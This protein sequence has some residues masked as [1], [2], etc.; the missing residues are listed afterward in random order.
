MKIK[1]PTLV[2]WCRAESRPAV[3]SAALAAVVL[4][5]LVT[6][7][8]A[9]TPTPTPP[10]S[11]GGSVEVPVVNLDVLVTDSDG[12]PVLD[13]KASD[14][15]LTVDGEPVPLSHFAPPTSLSGETEPTAEAARQ[16]GPTP[17]PA[18]EGR[19]Y[20]IVFVD[21]T[22]YDRQRLRAG[23]EQVS[24]FLGGTGKLPVPVMV[25]SFDGRLRICQSF[26]QNRDA[27]LASLD[28]CK[29]SSATRLDL[30]HEK[31]LMK[32]R[33]SHVAA[34]EVPPSDPTRETWERQV[35]ELYYQ[36]EQSFDEVA[37]DQTEAVLDG[38]RHCVGMLAG[39]PGRK[40]IVLM[41]DGVDAHATRTM[42]EVWRGT[43]TR[44]QVRRERE[45]VRA[46]QRALPK[47]QGY[48]HATPELRQ[49]VEV[50]NANRITFFTLTSLSD[51]L[52][53]QLSAEGS[54]AG[55][56]EGA[57]AELTEEIVLYRMADLTGGRVLSTGPDLAKQL[58]KVSEEMGQLYLLAFVPPVAN[59]GKFHRIQVAV[60]RE[61]VTVSHRRGWRASTDDDQLVAKTLA[62]A[63]METVDNPLDIRVEEIGREPGKSGEVK[64][65]IMV[66]MPIAKLVLLPGEKS[67]E[68]ATSLCLVIRDDAERLSNVYRE[69]FPVTV[70]DDQLERALSSAA[71]FRKVL[72]MR[73][74]GGL[75]A[76][77]VR[78]DV[79]NVVSTAVLRV[80]P[81]SP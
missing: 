79:A 8:L 3:R 52:M 29:E 11:F 42:F 55:S 10:R 64:V 28:C 14:F 80:A 77:G 60:D 66:R 39:I 1:M 81:E 7:S 33:I 41:S 31:M 50:A 74:G 70:P 51:R 44:I 63:G 65:D 36:I 6:E 76:V 75:I 40:S 57:F 2:G 49:L 62:A 78:D 34:A 47:S 23:L 59:D 16:A 73:K 24:E 38:L 12:A 5:A 71:G 45:L 4:T 68:G 54:S 46:L 35:L 9:A 67:H 15:R 58:R 19:Q 22:N 27:L 21:L 61:G 72:Q 20:V 17:V 25:M 18:A 56:T 69:A 32:R 30:G 43:F 13:L 26:T 48:P 53:K 37:R